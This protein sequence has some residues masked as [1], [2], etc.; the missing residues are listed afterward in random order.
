V[1]VSV[2]NLG[3]PQKRHASTQQPSPSMLPVDERK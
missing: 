2:V 1:D 3:P